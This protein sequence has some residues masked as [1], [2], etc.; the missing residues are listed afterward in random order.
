MS[1][2]D[3]PYLN[4]GLGFREQPVRYKNLKPVG[5]PAVNLADNINNDNDWFYEK[6]KIEAEHQMRLRNMQK[7]KHLTPVSY[8][9]REGFTGGGKR[10]FTITTDHLL[11][12]IFIVMVCMV[13]MQVLNW[14]EMRAMIKLL[15][16]VSLDDAKNTD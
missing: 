8:N 13:I 7:T 14:R 16:S 5:Q 11:I 15:S 10:G 9:E 6:K 3:E 4:E 12:L 1:W 2:L